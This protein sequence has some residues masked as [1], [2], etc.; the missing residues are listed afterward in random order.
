MATRDESYCNTTTDLL[1]VEPKIETYDRKRELPREAFANVAGI[2]YALSDAGYVGRLFRDGIDLGA[3]Q[4]SVGAVD[5]DGE[6]YYDD[7]TDK[8]TLATT[9]APTN[10]DLAA[11]SGTW[12]SIK[13]EAVARASERI[14]SYVNKPILKRVGATGKAESGRDWDDAVIEAT[15]IDACSRLLAPYDPQRAAELRRMVYNPSPALGEPLGIADMIKAGH[16]TLWNETTARFGAGVIR[17]VS[18]DATTTGG[19]AELRGQALVYFDLVKVVIDGEGTV[20]EGVAS[21]VTYSVAVGSAT[22]LK[23]NEVFS[24]RVIDCNWQQ[25]AHGVELRFLPGKYVLSDEWEVELRGGEPDS[26]SSLR[27]VEVRRL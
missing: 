22:G 2:V 27:S 1:A 20:T 25:L 3:A 17:E 18:V 13:T 10:Y 24:G 23:T 26:G 15:A 19:I 4:A 7:A 12:T 16:L 8:L 9:N 11:A 21:T 5:A 6:W 14:R